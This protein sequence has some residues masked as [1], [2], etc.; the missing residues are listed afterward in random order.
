MKLL[1]E[2]SGRKKINNF[3]PQEAFIFDVIF[4]SFFLFLT[5][6][7]VKRAWARARSK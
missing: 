1:I 6:S 2:V 3:V 7:I 5:E 4:F